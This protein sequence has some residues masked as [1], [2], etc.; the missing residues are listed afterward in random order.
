MSELNITVSAGLIKQ[1]VSQVE[2]LE[3]DKLE[4]SS[5]IKEVFD[6]ARAQGLEVSVLKQLIKIRKKKQEDIEM[7]EELLEIYKRALEQS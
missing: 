5:Q 3:A 1:T 6:N 4:L 7:A 2:K